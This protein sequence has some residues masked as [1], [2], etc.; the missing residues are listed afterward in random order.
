MPKPK[1]SSEG[2]TP[3][4]APENSAPPVTTEEAD[5]LFE[6]LKRKAEA[7]PSKFDARELIYEPDDAPRPPPI[8]AGLGISQALSPKGWVAY[9][10]TTGGDIKVLTP[11]S[12]TGEVVG[13]SKPSAA[14]RMMAAIAEE[15][16]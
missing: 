7:R 11:K 12:A 2:E 13:E 1:R 16:R 10:C 15:F 5:R 3:P 6:E 4:P 8:V 9:R 14:A